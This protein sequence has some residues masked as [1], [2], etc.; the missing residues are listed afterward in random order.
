MMET[1]PAQREV[2]RVLSGRGAREFLERHPGVDYLDLRPLL[3]TRLAPI[4][5]KEGLGLEC[6]KDGHLEWFARDLFVRQLR[7][8]LPGGWKRGEFAASVA[9]GAASA[10]LGFVDEA[11]ENHSDRAHDY[12]IGALFIPEGWLPES[13]DDPHIVEAFDVT[14]NG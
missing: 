14:R 11:I 1:T 3:G 10:A 7:H 6:K 2:R 13:A 9:L 5:L 12:L 4:R 8:G